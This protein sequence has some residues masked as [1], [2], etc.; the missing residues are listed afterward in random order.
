MKA[1][2]IIALLAV[3]SGCASKP[4][5]SVGLAVVDDVTLA[6]VRAA[7]DAYLGSTVR[8]GGII[9]ATENKADHTLV[10]VV[11]RTLEN[12]EQPLSNSAS[13][14]RFVA[15]FNGF[16]DPLVYK[17]DRRLTVVGQIDGS[18]VRPIGEFDYRFPLVAVSDSRLFAEPAKI[19]NY[20]YPDPWLYHPYYYHPFPHR[21]SHW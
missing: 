3:F 10:F 21:H 16:V 20:Y 14:G 9:T 19:R 11:A 4:P 1:L 7:G 2:G 12:N 13:D 5:S 8:W 17:A 6:T 15:R 18:L